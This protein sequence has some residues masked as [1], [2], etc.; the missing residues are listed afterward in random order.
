MDNN[1]KSRVYVS[2]TSAKWVDHLINTIDDKVNSHYASHMLE[3]DHKFNGNFQIVL[4][5]NKGPRLNL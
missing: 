5:E 4:F 1:S 3:D 2:S